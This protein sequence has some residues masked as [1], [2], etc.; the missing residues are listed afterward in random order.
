MGT[1][2]GMVSAPYCYATTVYI[3]RFTVDMSGYHSRMS[4]TV[5]YGRLSNNH[6]GSVTW[7]LQLWDIYTGEAQKRDG[8][9]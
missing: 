2:S 4:N 6:N 1:K 7:W 3:D 9:R 8:M 5:D